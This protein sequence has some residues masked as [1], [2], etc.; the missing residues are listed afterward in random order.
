MSRISASARLNSF[1]AE[2]KNIFSTDGVVLYCKI[3]NKI[4]KAQTRFAV[5]SHLAKRKH[6]NAI[7]LRNA[8]VTQIKIYNPSTRSTLHQDLFTFLVKSDISLS[9]LNNTCFRNYIEKFVNESV[10][11]E[12]SMKRF[13]LTEIYEQTINMIRNSVLGKKLWVSIDEIIYTEGRCIVHVVIG[14]LEIDSPSKT[15]LLT[16]EMLENTNYQSICNLFNESLLLLW[17]NGI[18]RDDIFLFITD[19]T[20]H[21]IKAGKVLGI[22]YTKMIHTTCLARILNCFAENIR[23]NYRKVDELI[24]NTNKMFLEVPSRVMVFKFETPNMPLLRPQPFIACWNTWLEAAF[25]YSEHYNE[26]CRVVKM[27]DKN[28]ALSI[29]VLHTIIETPELANQLTFIKANYNKLQYFVSDLD[30]KNTCLADSMKLLENVEI[31]LSKVSRNIGG[32]KN[33]KFLSEINKNES[34]ETLKII[35]DIISGKNIFH[36]CLA[37]HNYNPND[38]ALFK[39]APLSAANVERSFLK[40]KNV[41]TGNNRGDYR[42]EHLKMPFVVQFITNIFGKMFY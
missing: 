18:R 24:T 33:Y 37:K 23:Y 26:F 41:L 6:K 34:Y 35:S 10:P 30:R 31:Y 9:N 20:P 27:F 3:C 2:F 36:N 17:P 7:S 5:I 38:I 25:H 42:I 4:V 21:M 12:S 39:N 8:E 16:T 22:Q 32:L 28:E 1:V 11:D 13:Y 19:A 29:K 40:Y 14:T 15:Y